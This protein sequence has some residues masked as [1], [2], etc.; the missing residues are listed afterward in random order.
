[1]AIISALGSTFE[2]LFP[3]D[4]YNHVKPRTLVVE[5]YSPMF[6]TISS[7]SIRQIEAPNDLEKS[8][9]VEDAITAALSELSLQQQRVLRRRFGFDGPESTLSEIAADENVGPERI[10]QIEARALRNLRSPARIA[11]AKLRACAP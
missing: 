9:A 2:E 10:R 7:R 1:M 4:L 3:L 11:A 5:A 8:H 6:Q